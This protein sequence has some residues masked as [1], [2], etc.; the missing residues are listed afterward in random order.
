MREVWLTVSFVNGGL[1]TSVFFLGR[2]LRVGNFCLGRIR[3][4]GVD[5]PASLGLMVG[6]LRTSWSGLM[7]SKT[8][9]MDG[10]GA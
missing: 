9:M 7:R 3:R 8:L 2:F 4:L 5:S 10:F 6:F 1:V